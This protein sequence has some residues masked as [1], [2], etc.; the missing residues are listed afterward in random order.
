[1]YMRMSVESS[2]VFIRGLLRACYIKYFTII[3]GKFDPGVLRCWTCH[4]MDGGVT[5]L[6]GCGHHFCI[7]CLE[8]LHDDWT[9]GCKQ[10]CQQCFKINVPGKSDLRNLKLNPGLPYIPGLNLRA[11][12]SDLKDLKVIC[13]FV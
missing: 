13:D 8:E 11:G 10:P 6:D 9:A 2:Q 4:T 12:M 5:T 3:Y 7:P 1:M